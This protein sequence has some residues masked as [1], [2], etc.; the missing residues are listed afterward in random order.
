ML[1]F[2]GLL[3]LARICYSSRPHIQPIKLK[4]NND[5]ECNSILVLLGN[6]SKIAINMMT[7]L[8]LFVCL[9]ITLV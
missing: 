1:Q 5:R 7:N 2:L 9:A 4:W 6:I 8:D 3:K